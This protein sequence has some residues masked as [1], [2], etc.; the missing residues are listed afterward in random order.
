MEKEVKKVSLKKILQSGTDIQNIPELVGILRAFSRDVEIIISRK[1]DKPLSYWQSANRLIPFISQAIEEDETSLRVEAIICDIFNGYAHAIKLAQGEHTP[2]CRKMFS[3][4]DIMID[5]IVMKCDKEK[6]TAY[7][8]SRDEEGKAVFAVDIPEV[9][10]ISW[11]DPRKFDKERKRYPYRVE[12]KTIEE[13]NESFLRKK[14][15]EL[16]QSEINKRFSPHMAAVIQSFDIESMNENLQKLHRSK[17]QASQ[18]LNRLQE[19]VSEPSPKE[20]MIGTN[21]EQKKRNIS[22]PGEQ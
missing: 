8:Y 13:P 4:K 19:Q 10:Q 15:E 14:Y 3:Y 16:S 21:N 18:F 1:G 20:L 11:H 2:M 17:M 12:K 7:G 9:G 22:V 5:R 6:H